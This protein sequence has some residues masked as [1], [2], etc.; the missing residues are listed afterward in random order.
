MTLNWLYL[1]EQV[2][3]HLNSRSDDHE[4]YLNDVSNS[5]ENEIEEILHEASRKINKFKE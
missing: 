1:C 3:Y 2:I 4:A 5:Y